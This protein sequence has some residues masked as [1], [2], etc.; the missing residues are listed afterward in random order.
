MVVSNNVGITVLWLVDL[1]VGVLPCELLA[2]ING[3]QGK[4]E[5]TKR[6][7]GE[8]EKSVQSFE[9]PCL[10][11]DTT[12]CRRGKFELASLQQERLCFYSNPTF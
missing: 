3:L 2:W 6:R 5:R 4:D 7:R 1:Q 8:R 9:A 11:L 10:K 12:E